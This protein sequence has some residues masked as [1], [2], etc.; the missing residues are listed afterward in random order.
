MRKTHIQTLAISLLIPN[1][2]HGVSFDNINKL[3][4]NFVSKT[5]EENT[6]AHLAITD[7]EPDETNNT[8]PHNSP[9][10]VM[11]LSLIQHSSTLR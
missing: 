10:P 4:A 11:Q 7:R 9:P 6:K 2:S 3:T 8:S 5:W 1:V